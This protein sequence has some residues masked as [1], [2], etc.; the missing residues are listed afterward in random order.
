M[1]A[2]ESVLRL[3]RAN[4]PGLARLEI[5]D[6]A[7]A[8]A[9]D[10]RTATV[11][12]S[13]ATE[14]R[15]RKRVVVWT[16]AATVSLV[17]VALFGLPAL[18]ERLAPLIPMSVEQ[19]LGDA[20]D[21]R[22]AHARHRQSRRKPFECGPAETEKAGRAALDKVMDRLQRAAGS[23]DP[24]QDRGRAP[25]RGQRHCAAGRTHLRVSSG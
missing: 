21:G 4:S 25:Q 14:R 9:I 1:S 20:I 3:G 12:R 18:V 10:D 5:R 19:K 13:G 23:A 24:A 16:I 22:C 15:N 8:A 17:L 7:L 6:P 11:D 2:P